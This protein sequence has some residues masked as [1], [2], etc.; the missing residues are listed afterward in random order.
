VAS[1]NLLRWKLRVER[2][3]LRGVHP[4]IVTSIRIWPTRHSE[5]VKERALPRENPYDVSDLLRHG[6]VRG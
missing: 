5:E 4:F 6:A 1:D 2:D 3:L